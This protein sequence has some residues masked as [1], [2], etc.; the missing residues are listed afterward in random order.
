MSFQKSW[1]SII[2]R[3]LKHLKGIVKEQTEEWMK[4]RQIRMQEI[5]KENFT[6]GEFSKKVEIWH[7]KK[8]KRVLTTKSSTE[9]G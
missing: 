7:R 5:L 1:E 9:I 8:L 2:A 6:D 4:S 3:K